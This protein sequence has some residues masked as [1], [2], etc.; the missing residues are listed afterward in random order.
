MVGSEMFIIDL[1]ENECDGVGTAEE[2]T[3]GTVM[4]ENVLAIECHT[5]YTVFFRKK[6]KNYTDKLFKQVVWTKSYYI[7]VHVHRG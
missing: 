4:M 1:A 6:Y 5:H 7:R 3:I 2:K